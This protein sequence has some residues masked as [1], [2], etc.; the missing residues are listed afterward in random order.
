MTNPPDVAVAPPK[1][2]LS[3]IIQFVLFLGLG[4]LIIWLSLRVLTPE[5]KIQI[6]NSFRIANYNWVILTIFL[7]VISHV[8]RSLRWKLLMKPLGYHPSLKKHLLR[9]NGGIFC[10]LSLSAAGRS[11]TLRRSGPL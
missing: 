7:G 8:F 1:K 9:G 5:E 6:L 3:T 10:Q 4:L 11:D 2:R